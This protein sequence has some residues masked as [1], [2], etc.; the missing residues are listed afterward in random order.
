[1]YLKECRG[2]KIWQDTQWLLLKKSPITLEVALFLGRA[3]VAMAAILL[4]RSRSR[5]IQW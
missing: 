1:M 3:G 5:V 2:E 4:T